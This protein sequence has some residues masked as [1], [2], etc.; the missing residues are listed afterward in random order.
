MSERDETPGVRVRTPAEQ[1]AVEVVHGGFT[2]FDDAVEALVD[3]FADEREP[4]GGEQAKDIVTAVWTARLAGQRRWPPVTEAERL[5]GVLAGLAERDLVA[6]PHF[7]C[8]GRC[9]T[10]EIGAEATVDSRGYVFFHQQDTEAAVNGRGLMLSFG[11]FDGTPERN[12]A[13]GSEVAAALTSAG[14]PVEWDGTPE[15]R[16]H[17]TPLEWRIRLPEPVA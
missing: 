14:L 3:Y 6:E 9:G 13:V 1:F 10:A 8:C 4:V 7:T 5:L 12:R 15:R 16:L 11:A 17:V 2:D